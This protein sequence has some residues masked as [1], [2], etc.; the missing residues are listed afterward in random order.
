MLKADESTDWKFKNDNFSFYYQS[1]LSHIYVNNLLET[2]KCGLASFNESKILHQQFIH[3]I[4]E[5]L[6]NAGYQYSYAPIT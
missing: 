4:I 1:Q 3:A 5:Y 6:N 2:G